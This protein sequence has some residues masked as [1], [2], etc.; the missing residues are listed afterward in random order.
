MI[1]A[2]ARSFDMG[3]GS[4]L[5]NSEKSRP[6]NVA[7]FEWSSSD[8]P[9]K[10]RL[11]LGAVERLNLAV[12][13]GFK[14]LPRRGLEVG[15]LLLGRRIPE[16]VPITVV[17][18]F[19]PI[20][21]EHRRGPSY[22]LSGK[23]T[24]LLEKRLAVGADKPGMAVVGYWRSHTRP[25][26]CLDDEDVA[27]IRRYFSDPSQLFLLIKP[28][29]TEKSVGTFLFWEGG[30]IQREA[31]DHQFPF[32]LSQLLAG[33]LRIVN[34]TENSQIGHFAGAPEP[35]LERRDDTMDRGSVPGALSQSGRQPNIRQITLSPRWIWLSFAAAAVLILLG[36][37]FLRHS[38]SAPR[39]TTQNT[40]GELSLRVE[41]DGSSLK[42]SWNRNS[43]PI[44]NAF[45]GTL[46]V[47]DGNR[48]HV[49]ELDKKQLTHG[50]FVYFRGS[51]DV[52]FELQVL[53][54]GRVASESV[55][56]LFP[57]SESPATAGPPP[58]AP[59]ERVPT[60]EAPK[61]ARRPRSVTPA[62]PDPL[63]DASF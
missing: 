29:A 26:L 47:T 22:L 25:G 38:A 10:I 17:E 61:G 34:H 8:K 18:D 27:I 46:R 41:Q 36:N 37:T 24:D 45:E 5:P 3:F 2:S 63:N 4:G 32:D 28:S 1:S 62:P 56:A 58:A 52:N 51:S 6:A 40:A 19:E 59:P 12:K 57:A 60:P 13:E 20:E 55:R 9:I 54:Q 23:D 21:S 48:S 35:K 49:L 30:D 15:G 31:P 7:M 43:S 11:S 50:S 44:L 14:A 33:G 53:T 39:A 16:K 42:L